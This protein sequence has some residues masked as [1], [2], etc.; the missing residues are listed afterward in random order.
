MPLYTQHH[1]GMDKPP[2]L[3]LQLHP[4][5]HPYPHPHFKEGAHLA[6]GSEQG[7]LLFVL[8]APC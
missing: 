7:S 5:A 2:K 4:W 8:T 1:K 3:S 6:V